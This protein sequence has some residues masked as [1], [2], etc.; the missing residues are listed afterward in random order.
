MAAA[1]EA[2]L[3]SKDRGDVAALKLWK[4]TAATAAELEAAAAALD[5]LGDRSIDTRRIEQRKLDAQ[6]GR[7]LVLLD[8]IDRAFRQA[9][10]VDPAILIPT[11]HAL[12]SLFGGRSSASAPTPPAP[13][14][15]LP[16]PGP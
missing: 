9:H 15:P 11:F 6:D 1:I 5:G 8:V 7:V 3:A 13:P 10:R 14:A 2:G 16:P 12:A 4:V